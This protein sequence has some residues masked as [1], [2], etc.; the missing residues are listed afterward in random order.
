MQ[1][2][3]GA[4]PEREAYFRSLLEQVS[5]LILVLDRRGLLRYVNPAAERS[6][7]YAP[8]RVVGR[9]M[10]RFIHPED[11][12]SVRARLGLDLLAV[13][14]GRSVE[15]RLRHHAGGWRAM[16]AIL[17]NC[18]ADPE[19]RGMVVNLRD[20]S[21]R[22]QAEDALQQRNA[23]LSA[24]QETTLDL[25]S[26][27]DLDSLL[28]NIVRRAGQLMGTTA[29]Y[30]DL[31]DPATGQL[32]PRVGLGVLAESLQFGVQPGEGMAGRVWQSGQVLAIDDYDAWPGRI[33]GFSRGTLSAIVG[34]PLFME[35]RVVGVLGLAYPAGVRRTFGPEAVD[36]L[37]QFA[38]LAVIA[39]NNA[40]LFSTA[41]QELAERKRAEAEVRR[42]H[43]ELEQRV[44]QRTAQLEATNKE[45]E[46]FSYS[47]SHDLRAP[48]RSIDGFSQAL[49]EDYADRLD[50][51]GRLFL[52]R[53]REASQRMG[54]LI[55][56]L[57]KLSRLMRSALDYQPVDLSALVESIATDLQRGEP[58]RPAEFVIAAGQTVLAD[59][60]L[61][62]VALENLLGNA[63][64]FT[65]KQPAARI[66]FGVG[67]GPDGAPA[68]FVRDNGAGFN[69]AYVGKLFGAFQRL[70][71]PQEFPGTGIGLATVQRIIH[72]HGGRV[73]A[74]G[75]TGQGA[76]F[77]FT[78]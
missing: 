57:L 7:G 49:L 33:G 70:H 17:T 18:L 66:E 13:E 22:K 56:D 43:A 71:T 8:A 46:A 40:R 65:A 68:Y 1:T 41:Q 48:L 35:G 28:E 73:W 53:I 11:W 78:L 62:R 12:A 39:M 6:L 74:E 9:H 5:D 51:E 26:Q 50:E 31:L 55:D 59:P 38:R 27:L 3:S 21:E 23:Y 61:L 58:A 72:Q 14:T 16:E 42:L 2:L 32:V 20:I 63:W 19:I 29:G 75:E 44:V 30:L 52:Q 24:L 64:K 60:R 34:V 45:L 47:V 76:T 77:Y 54:Q 69:M 25:I 67:Q 15:F 4:S 36:L 37:S 10:F